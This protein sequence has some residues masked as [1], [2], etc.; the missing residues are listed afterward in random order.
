MEQEKYTLAEAEAILA[1]K[2]CTTWGHEYDEIKDMAGRIVR[3]FCGRCGA[4]F[5]EVT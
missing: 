3:I 2:R 4:E 1:R 5:K